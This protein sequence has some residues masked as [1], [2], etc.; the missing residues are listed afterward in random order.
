MKQTLF[1]FLMASC[2]FMLPTLTF[3]QQCG[4]PINLSASNI[5]STSATLSWS[6]STTST[7]I[8]VYNIEYKKSTATAWTL[9]GQNVQYPAN[10][11]NLTGLESGTTYQFRLWAVCHPGVSSGT[12]IAFSF[13]T[14]GPICPTFIING[15]SFN[16]LSCGG[17]FDY[18]LLSGS[19]LSGIV[20]SISG[21]GFIQQNNG[22]SVRVCRNGS[23]NINLTATSSC[24][25]VATKT[26]SEGCSLALNSVVY[27][28]Q[29]TQNVF[30][31]SDYCYDRCFG[32]YNNYEPATYTFPTNI[33]PSDRIDIAMNTSQFIVEQVSPISYF[34]VAKSLNRI[35][36][37]TNITACPNDLLRLKVTSTS[38]GCVIYMN[39]CQTGCP[40]SSNNLLNV[41]DK[42]ND[43]VSIFPN[44]FSDMLNI[45]TNH[46]SFVVSERKRMSLIN[47]SGKIVAESFFEGD[48]D[49]FDVSTLSQGIYFLNIYN[50]EGHLLSSNRVVKIK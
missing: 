15:Q 32:Q 1:Y 2:L 38:N 36:V 25:N 24:G 50:K 27:P 40:K 44:P 43:K 48:S 46:D 5:T 13:T 9:Y 14:L 20:W 49:Y 16:T 3:A 22:N 31:P 6:H 42:P 8:Y 37:R 18:T 23:G 17:C 19:V 41:T 34:T 35:I 11:L 47:I 21:G 30:N 28:N 29:S 26:I 10:T 4:T 12:S 39:F 33:P 45:K 7:S